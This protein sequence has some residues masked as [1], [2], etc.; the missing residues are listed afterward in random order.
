MRKLY[1]LPK[2][3][4]RSSRTD[5]PYSLCWVVEFD[6]DEINRKDSYFLCRKAGYYR[7]NDE[8]RGWVLG[9]APG[10]H[11]FSLDSMTFEGLELPPYSLVLY[12]ESAAFAFR[13]RY[14]GAG[15]PF[16]FVPPEG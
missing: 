11:A 15:Q 5:H 3:K 12:D 7:L 1:R 16:Q 10:R 4:Y 2:L 13:L 6:D 8:M 14:T 9:N